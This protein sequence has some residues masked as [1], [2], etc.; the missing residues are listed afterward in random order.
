MERISYQGVT[1]IKGIATWGVHRTSTAMPKDHY[2]W[3]F[4]KVSVEYAGIFETV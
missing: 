3:H 2:S 1:R 4:G